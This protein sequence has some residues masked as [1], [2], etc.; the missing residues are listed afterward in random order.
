MAGGPVSHTPVHKG[1][2]YDGNGKL[3]ESEK[4]SG[5]TIL[6]KH[7]DGKGSIISKPGVRLATSQDASITKQM[8]QIED[9]KKE[10]VELKKVNADSL[11]LIKDMDKRLHALEGKEK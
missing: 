9:L 8:N 5:V 10:N 1:A 11:A 6:R 7:P 3:S 4:N 2:N